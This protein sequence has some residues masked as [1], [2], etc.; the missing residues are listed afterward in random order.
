VPDIAAALPD[1]STQSFNWIEVGEAPAAIEQWRAARLRRIRPISS[2]VGGLL[3]GGL[4]GFAGVTVWPGAMAWPL[5]TEAELFLAVAVPVGVF[6]FFFNRWFLEWSA[7]VHELH[8]RRLAIFDGKLYLE[9]ASGRTSQWPLKQV[10]VSKDAVAG[11]WYS[12]GL[13]GGRATLTFYVPPPAAA[14]I[15]SAKN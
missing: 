8:V 11:G 7:R 9:Q 4:A 5:R 2:V 1:P 6:E 3:I 12:V 13:G 15:A 14:T 10:R